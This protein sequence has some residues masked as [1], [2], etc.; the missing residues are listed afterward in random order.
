[1]D[2]ILALINQ[3]RDLD[4]MQTIQNPYVIAAIVVLLA[5]SFWRK[6]YAAVAVIIV[7]VAFIP[8]SYYTLPKGEEEIDVAKVAIFAGGSAILGGILI[9]FGFVKGK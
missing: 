5:L 2:R 1:M 8:L 7:V 3:A 6:A 9:Y 4:W